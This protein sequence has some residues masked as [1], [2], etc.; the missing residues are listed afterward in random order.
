MID[1]ILFDLDGTLLPMDFEKFLEIYFSK[2][3]LVFQDLI[4]PQTLVKYIW[5]ATDAMIRN[6]EPLTNETVFFNKFSQLIAQD[7]EIYKRRFQKFYDAEF[8]ETKESVLDT[9]VIKESALSL[10]KKGYDL[11]LATN[12]IF[13]EK[14]I[15]HRLNWAGFSPGDFSYVTC[16]ERNHYCKPQ[17]QFFEELLKETKKR[18]EQCLMVGNDVQE[19]LVAAKLG[20]KTYLITDCLI[21]RTEAAITADFQGDYQDFAVFVNNLPS[22]I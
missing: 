9:A 20:I 14:A 19:D 4:E 11:I 3:G 18:P 13:P 5:A 10:K 2:M 22:V 7:P 15:R 12:P 21:H 17:L 16:Y 1:T 6:T 8:L